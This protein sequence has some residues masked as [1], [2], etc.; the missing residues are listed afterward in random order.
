M[1]T[2][3]TLFGIL[4]LGAACAAAVIYGMQQAEQ[5][6][7]KNEQEQQEAKALYESTN[8]V[9]NCWPVPDVAKHLDDD[10]TKYEEN[11]IMEARFGAEKKCLNQLNEK[12]SSWDV[13]QKTVEMVTNRVGQRDVQA[14]MDNATRTALAIGATRSQHEEMLRDAI[15]KSAEARDVRLAACAITVTHL[16]KQTNTSVYSQI[17]LRYEAELETWQSNENKRIWETPEDGQ[18]NPGK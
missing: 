14:D 9:V 3:K 5:K 18:K 4:C 1:K 17:F 11:A 2:T 7:H 16:M 13:V 6:R 8:T 12:Y 15:M 10:S